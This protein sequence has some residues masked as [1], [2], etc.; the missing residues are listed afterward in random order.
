MTKLQTL[1]HHYTSIV[2]VII[3]PGL[4]HTFNRTKSSSWQPIQPAT[5]FSITYGDGFKASG[6]LVSDTL[7]IGGLI[8]PNQTFAEVL[9]TKNLNEAPVIDGMFGLGFYEC[10]NSKS[11]PPLNNLYQLGLLSKALFS[12]YLNL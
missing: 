11:L 6:L 4:A 10:A 12:V 1:F 2:F 9:L 8:V 3:S 7:T 5:K